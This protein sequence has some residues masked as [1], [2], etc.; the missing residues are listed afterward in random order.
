MIEYQHQAHHDFFSEM[1]H[2]AP[3][4]LRAQQPYTPTVK[5][6]VYGFGIILEEIIGRNGPYSLALE[7]MEPKG[8]TVWAGCRETEQN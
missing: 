4:L 3:E 6:D 5:G 2:V 1:L 8:T 7:K